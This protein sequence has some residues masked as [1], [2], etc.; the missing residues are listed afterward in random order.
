[1]GED[2]SV[3][4]KVRVVM[5]SSDPRL[6][7]KTGFVTMYRPMD[8]GP[9]RIVGRIVHVHLDVGVRVFHLDHGDRL[10]EEDLSSDEQQILNMQAEG[11]SNVSSG[12][13]NGYDIRE[14]FDRAAVD[15][16]PGEL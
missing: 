4:Q 13:T 1:M 11:W 8:P 10:E 7:G 5:A 2:L 6:H 15:K 12:P 3:G 9:D 14:G 16:G